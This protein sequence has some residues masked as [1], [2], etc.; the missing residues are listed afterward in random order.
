MFQRTH[1]TLYTETDAGIL[2]RFFLFHYPKIE[3]KH[4]LYITQGCNTNQRARCKPRINKPDETRNDDARDKTCNNKCTLTRY[5]N[6]NTMYSKRSTKADTTGTWN[7][8]QQGQWGTEDTGIHILIRGNRNQVC[9]MRQD[10][11]GL[12]SQNVKNNFQPTTMKNIFN[13]Y[14]F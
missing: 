7:N 9:V 3:Y 13:I 6:R 8:N 1:V 2:N 5:V 11:P 10:S 14:I 12:N 4:V